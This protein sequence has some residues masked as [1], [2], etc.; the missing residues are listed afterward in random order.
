MRYSFCNDVFFVRGKSGACLYDFPHKKL[1]HFNSNGVKLIERIIQHQPDEL[2]LSEE[3]KNTIQSLVELSL[4]CYSDGLHCNSGDYCKL[5]NGYDHKWGLVWIEV[6]KQCNLKCIHCY[7]N[8]GCNQYGVMS[9]KDFKLTIDELKENNV[10]RI[11]LIGG[12]PM[13]LGNTILEM[14]KYAIGQFDFIEIFTNGTLVTNDQIAFFKKH[15]IHVA[16]SLYSSYALMHDKVTQVSNS[17]KKTMLTIKALEY[18]NIKYR[19]STVL[20][21]G[22]DVGNLRNLTC[23]DKPSTDVIRMVG[24]ANVNMLNKELLYKILITKDS[25]RKEISKRSFVKNINWHNC[26]EKHLYI[27]YDLD[28]FPCV[29]ERR[30]KHG[31]IKDKRLHDII[32]SSILH[33]NKD[34]IEE[35]KDC[36]YRYSCQDCRPNSLDGNIYSKPWL[37]TYDPQTGSWANKDEY[38]Q[39]ILKSF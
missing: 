1:Y 27:S 31:N 19:L 10:H 11:Q 21:N 14:L 2:L 37:C 26:F 8:S 18:N 6:T 9:L 12:E 29:M 25:F 5:K 32:S 28:V 16:L 23:R 22:I 30:I 38:I 15:N 36:E 7:E 24:R 33:F 20:M 39:K 3:E 34:C 13:M 17:F 4:I 35:C